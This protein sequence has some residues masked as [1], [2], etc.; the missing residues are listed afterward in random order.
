MGK[1][2][3]ANTFVK[4]LTKNHRLHFL[5]RYI[6]LILPFHFSHHPL[7]NNFRQEV[8]K[9]GSWYVCRGCLCVY[10]SMLLSLFIT[11]FVNPFI[12]FSL[13]EK[14]LLVLIVSSPTWIGFLFKF[15]NRILKDL[16]RFSLGLGWGIAI[17]ELWLQPL[18]RDKIV[19]FFLMVIFWFVFKKIRSFQIGKK[20]VTLC[21]NCTALNDNACLGYKKKFE[22][23]RK[24]SREISDF[25]QQ[26]LAWD[27]IQRRLQD[28]HIS[29]IESS[30]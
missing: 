28:S 5:K 6:Q 12:N 2:I 1:S 16:L 11:V 21:D 4:A 22:A 19:I 18:W 3:L 15:T 7:C 30:V 20:E 23:E 8:V 27:D 26:K 24:Y 17:G 10:S 25:L 29:K 13:W 9:I 14:F